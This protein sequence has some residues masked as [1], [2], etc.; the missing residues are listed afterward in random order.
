MIWDDILNDGLKQESVTIS[1]EFYT[2][3]WKCPTIQAEQLDFEQALISKKDTHNG[4]SVERAYINSKEYHDKFEKLPLN[5]HVQQS[6]YLQAGRLLEKVDGQ[7]QE[8]MLAINARTGEF[9]VD[10]FERNGNTFKTSFTADEYQKIENCPDSVIVMHNHSMNGRPSAQDML[11]YL[12]EEKMRLSIVVCHD[13]TVYSISDVKPEMKTVYKKYLEEAKSRMLGD[14]EAK[15][16]AT[17]RL[18]EF[19]DTK[20]SKNHKLFEVEKL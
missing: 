15:R 6:L 17:T 18:Y 8:R 1:P 16:F 14:E 4:Y 2:K 11:T 3:P 5:S 20:L 7:S 19:N 13:G 10:N 12:K 9:I